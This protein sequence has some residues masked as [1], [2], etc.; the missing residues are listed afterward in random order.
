MVALS[1]CQPRCPHFQ[2]S[3][4]LQ[5][6]RYRNYP[7]N[8][9]RV[10]SCPTEICAIMSFVGISRKI[11]VLPART[12][13]KAGAA[14]WSGHGGAGELP[15]TAVRRLSGPSRRSVA[16][17]WLGWA[18]S[19]WPAACRR[20]RLSSTQKEP[21]AVSDEQPQLSP[22]PYRRYWRRLRSVAR[23]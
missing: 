22:P 11:S 12:S 23:P 15:P 6:C 1:S 4:D 16:V 2:S 18:I 10:S 19:W 17:P 3:S 7:A 21:Q 9:T 14:Q 20:N 8:I 5:A 13:E